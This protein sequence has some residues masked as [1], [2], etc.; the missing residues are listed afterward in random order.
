VVDHTLFWAS[1]ATLA[2][3][4]YL[5]ALL[6]APVLT[7]LVR[8][9]Q[10]VGAFG[11]R[12]FDKYVWQSPIPQFDPDNPMHQ[13]LVQLE[14]SSRGV[15]EAVEIRDSVGFQAARRTIRKALDA[16]GISRELDTAVAG[17]LR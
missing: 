7:Q 8:P 13:R 17:L 5:V 6:N 14:G 11:P 2:E 4:Q 10:A 12:D 16:A 15:A 9:F 1:G 3:A